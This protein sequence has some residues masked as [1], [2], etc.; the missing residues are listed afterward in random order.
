VSARL[1]Q[2]YDLP[3]TILEI[4]ERTGI[5]PESL[6]LEMTESIAMQN[7]ENTLKTLWKLHEY[8][9]QVA[10]DDFG[11]GYSS[12]A[13]LRKLPIHTLKIDRAFIREM[14][15]N[16][17]DQTIV[18]AILAMAGALNIKVVAEGVE[19]AEQRDLLK[20]FGC[21]QAQ[22]YFFSRPVPAEEFAR[23]L[24]RNLTE[25]PETPSCP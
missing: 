24:E 8:S 13:C 4:L 1:F 7:L 14:D 16:P 18:K 6:E 21:H 22:G 2:K 9:I 17:E 3:A 10:M 25:V 12:L 20:E 11:T 5:G 19:R 23:L 15:R